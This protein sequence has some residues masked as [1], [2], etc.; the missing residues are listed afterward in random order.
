MKTKDLKEVLTLLSRNLKNK[1]IIE[2][3]NSFVFNK[4]K[5]FVFNDNFA[6]EIPFKSDIQAIVPALELS[7]IINGIT[8]E[9]IKI[10]C[11]NNQLTIAAGSV[12]AQINC[13]DWNKESVKLLTKDIKWMKVPKDFNKGLKL[14][15]FSASTD[16][17][18]P[19]FNSISVSKNIIQSSDDFRASKFEMKGRMKSFLLPLSCAI[20]LS[21]FKSVEYIV[22]ENWIHVK[23]EDGSIFHSRILVGK[24]PDTSELFE[25]EGDI[26]ELPKELSQTIDLV[27]VLAEGDFITDKKIQI[28]IYEGKM[29]C[30]A[31]NETGWIESDIELD[32]RSSLSFLI[33]PIFFG[34]VLKLSS[35]A[36][37]DGE[38]IEFISGNF[39]HMMML[40]EEE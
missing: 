27:S 32:T 3:H 9:D 4:N 36:I 19:V 16:I 18:Q 15:L 24:F 1:S 29:R 12:K 22:T 17:S 40:F 38:K 10:S 14:T 13:Y 20:M 25:V 39:R 21:Q 8:E 33:N 34:E 37:T 7:K 11:K 23:N 28:D 35:E 30:R 6:L 2:E 26:F 31:E 5:I